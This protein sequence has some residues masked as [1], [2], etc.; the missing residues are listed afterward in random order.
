MK[1]KNKKKIIFTSYYV[2]YTFLY[3]V[4]LTLY[5][6]SAME[7]GSNV[8]LS[9]YLIESLF[10]G[11]GFLLYP[12]ISHFLK[13]TK[14]I[15]VIMSVIL[16]TGSFVGYFTKEIIT[17]KT[18]CAL[19]V[20]SLGY[21]GGVAYVVM[22]KSFTQDAGAGFCIGIGGAMAVVLQFLLQIG[23][24]TKVLVPILIIPAT[25]T[26]MIFTT[27]TGKPGEEENIPC[28]ENK[29]IVRIRSLQM[30]V[31]CICL[32]SLAAYYD[33][34]VAVSISYYTYLTYPRLFVAIG[35]IMT[36]LLWEY[37]DHMFSNY[38]MMGMALIALLIPVMLNDGRYGIVI[39][40]MFYIYVG[41][42]VAYFNL[43]FMYMAVKY[44]HPWMS[45]I[46]RVLDNL[47]TV[48]FLVVAIGT[49]PL[50]WIMVIS[51]ALIGI[52]A[53]MSLFLSRSGMETE[54]DEVLLSDNEKIQGFSDEFGLT[55]REREVLKCL[56]TGDDK[57][58]AIASQLGISRRTLTAHTT[59]I[60]HK[61]DT[62]SRIGLMRKYM[63]LLK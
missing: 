13:N 17:I 12:V 34:Q 26:L 28:H 11:I 45:V 46:Y 19:T 60:Y 24:D 63:D 62:S 22:T 5:S 57:T 39:M 25:I 58:E 53:L 27:L 47:L 29:N 61:T 23:Y 20:A 52:S 55:D 59:A 15:T 38:L 37:K 32:I 40:S 21:L 33:D 10:C 48:H 18:A 7:L 42:C 50:L 9:V 1:E 44:S 56:L 8:H 31:F 36:G 35:A 30:I 51:V 54:S 4:V 2:I 16:I 43:S 14:I 49:L 41:G 6:K 3:M